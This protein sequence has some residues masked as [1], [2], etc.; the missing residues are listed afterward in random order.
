MA[1]DNN[2]PPGPS[3]SAGSVF[4]VSSSYDGGYMER[5]M[6]IAPDKFRGE[7]GSDIN[8]TIPAHSEANQKLANLQRAFEMPPRAV[9]ESLFENFW[10]RCYFWD[11]IVDRSQV[12]EIAPDKVS[13]LLLQSIFLAGS[14]MLSPSQP[15]NYASAQDY[16]TRAKT[17][18]WLDCEKDPLTL[19][20]AASLMHWWNPHGPERVSTNTS[21]F[22][23][24]ITVS[25]A[26]QMGIHRLKKPV[27]NESLRRR[28]WWSIVARD[29]LISLAHG[30]PQAINLE[31]SD[32]PKPTLEDFPNST[33]TGLFFIA[34]VDLS[35]IVGRFTR[36]KIRKSSSRDQNEDI[37]HSLYQ[38]NRT[39]PE[40]LRLSSYNS[41]RQ[42]NIYSFSKPYNL[43]SRQLNI[44]YLV[45]ITL[46]YRSKSLDDPFPT[47]AVLAASTV[48]GIF[49]DFLARDEVRFLGACFTFHLL[50]ASIA[51][52]SCYKYPE[53][54]ALAQEDLN[55]LA[56]AQEEMK[57]KWPSALGSIGSFDRMF[58]LA[59]ATQKKV[60]QLPESTLTPDQAAF[61]EDYNMTLCRMHAIL[62]PKRD[63]YGSR[64]AQHENNSTNKVNQQPTSVAESGHGNGNLKED[65]ILI[66]P[67]YAQG[68]SIGQQFIIEQPGLPDEP[69]NFDHMFQ[70]NAGQ[71][72]DA[73]GDWLFW[74][75]PPL[76]N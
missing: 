5:S 17:L 62:V 51:L 73:I 32:I 15:H 64:R 40:P 26:Q 42:S 74:D 68:E 70:E 61:F 37:G 47:A 60:A 45:M 36:H 57:K 25:L 13:P 38:W 49:E 75:Q 23:C 12:M 54:W 28:L 35:M 41:K 63:G 67:Y 14:R 21:S 66:P 11:P 19:L 46:L 44:L 4:S 56:Q 30:R 29:C 72:D 16:Y 52:L 6:Y 3:P 20:V 48:A 31:E 22:W 34:Y 59:V 65:M 2:P 8:Y 53:L 58:K 18:F 55:T 39:L 1:E 69:L 27:P 43:E 71:L 33:Q 7:D 50:A 76:D 10:T 24:R 9:R